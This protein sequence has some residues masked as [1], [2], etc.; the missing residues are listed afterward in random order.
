MAAAIS[1]MS[2][3]AAARGECC[4]VSALIQPAEWDDRGRFR[5]VDNLAARKYRKANPAVT[6]R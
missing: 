3:F 5:V 6:I 4:F 1:A 2:V